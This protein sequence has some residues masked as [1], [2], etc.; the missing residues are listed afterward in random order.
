M[1]ELLRI[2]FEEDAEEFLDALPEKTRLKFILC[3]R[4][5]SAGEKG[6]FF[7]KLSGYKNLWEFRVEAD[8]TWYRL[9]AFYSETEKSLIICTNGFTK[10]KNKTPKSQINKAIALKDSYHNK[11]DS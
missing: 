5:V 3:F 10:Q 6:R 9:F 2:E 4:R 1:K 11:D 7:T 8:K